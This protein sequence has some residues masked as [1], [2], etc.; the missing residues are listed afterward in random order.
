MTDC[1][2]RWD[3]T[4]SI[5]TITCK[6]F[7]VI[8]QNDTVAGYQACKPLIDRA[9]ARVLESGWYILGQ[10][11]AQFER[12]FSEYVGVKLG[13]GVASGTD[14]IEVALRALGIG[15]D[16]VVF[17]VSH[18]AVATIAGIERTGA[19][20]ALVDVDRDTYTMCPNHLEASIKALTRS[21]TLKAAAIVPV[22]LYGQPADIPAI[23]DLARRY[24]LLV[25]E[26]CAQAHG[27]ESGGRRVGS[28]GDAAAFSFYPTKNLGALGDAGI[29]VTNDHAVAER[30]RAIR[31]YG[32]PA[33]SS[34]S[35]GGVRGGHI[36]AAPGINS[37]L[38]ELQAAILNE[39]LSRLDQDNERRRCVADAYHKAL[40]DTPLILPT[41][42]S[43]AGHV[44]HQYVLQATDRDALRNFLQKRGVGTGIHYPH[45][46]HQQPAYLNRFFGCDQLPVTEQLVG[47]I[48]SLPM[49]PQLSDQQVDTICETIQAWICLQ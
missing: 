28:W 25:V 10:D 26:D 24:G 7:H 21:S 45:P 18:T 8:P 31:Q 16:E 11:V 32:W 46:I 34:P 49:Y 38:D 36:S 13:V 35:Q 22:H 40:V 19:S 48:V 33:D 47:D 9:I 20:V 29:V 42:R 4:E 1:D 6:A 44:Y 30:A 39:K 14:A 43:Q 15:P 17:T 12:G 23:M 41:H 3:I 2:V 37:R 5:S 27:A